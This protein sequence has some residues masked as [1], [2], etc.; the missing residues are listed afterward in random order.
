MKRIILVD[1]TFYIPQW[2]DG[3]HWQCYLGYDGISPYL[4]IRSFNSLQDA[5][6]FIREGSTFESF[7]VVKEF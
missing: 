1:G 6:K 5:E 2:N 7:S 3:H 4:Q